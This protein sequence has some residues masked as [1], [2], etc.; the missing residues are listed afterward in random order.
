MTIKIDNRYASPFLDNIAFM[1]IHMHERKIYILERRIMHFTKDIFQFMEEPD[2]KGIALPKLYLT[3]STKILQIIYRFFHHGNFPKQLTSQEFNS[4]KQISEVFKLPFLQSCL[5]RREKKEDLPLQDQLA[6][7]A[8]QQKPDQFCKILRDLNSEQV[9]L[10]HVVYF[11]PLF[12]EKLMVNF[13]RPDVPAFYQPLLQVYCQEHWVS[14]ENV[15]CF[16]KD[17]EFKFDCL[18]ECPHLDRRIQWFNVFWEKI[19]L[20]LL[21]KA[22]IQPL[23]DSKRLVEAKLWVLKT[24]DR[25]SAKLLIDEFSKI[26]N[27]QEISELLPLL[28]ENRHLA[29]SDEKKEE[30]LIANI[31]LQLESSV[32]YYHIIQN[33]VH[34]HIAIIKNSDSHKTLMEKLEVELEQYDFLIWN[35]T[36]FSVIIY[37]CIQSAVKHANETTAHNLKLAHVFFKPSEAYLHPALQ[38][39]CEVLNDVKIFLQKMFKKEFT[40]K[41]E[42]LGKSGELLK[43]PKLLDAIHLVARQ[44][45]CQAFSLKEEFIVQFVNIEW[46]Y[47]QSNSDFSKSELPF[48]QR[49][50]ETCQ[51]AGFGDELSAEQIELAFSTYIQKRIEI[52]NFAFALYHDQKLN[53]YDRNV[54]NRDLSVQELGELIESF[55]PELLKNFPMKT[56]KER[57]P[58]VAK[59][60]LSRAE[61]KRDV[62]IKSLQAYHYKNP[63]LPVK[64]MPISIKK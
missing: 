24:Q 1:H 54:Q 12:F 50:E 32:S 40:G 38:S 21:K 62:F 56:I 9:V 7:A 2:D 11:Q 19:P 5:E 18:A 27:E 46:Q 14:L 28:D 10:S 22:I 64:Y 33:I 43:G 35:E 47:E 15:L 17:Q 8:L 57:A 45:Y 16:F 34:Q 61:L 52:A 39:S 63:P 44:C 42:I 41:D 36:L 20:P 23:I 4:T 49:L 51:Q 37:A 29:S 13:I 58:S 48:F 53:V 25:S 59:C 30:V 31:F 60:L 55:Y 26:H 3:A 6:L